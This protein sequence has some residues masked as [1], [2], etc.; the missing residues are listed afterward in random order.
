M[1]SWL[2]PTC[3]LATSL[4][5]SAI[6]DLRERPVHYV[7]GA[8]IP[9]MKTIKKT[10]D[11]GLF[12][13]DNKKPEIPIRVTEGQSVGF[14]QTDDGR[15]QAH[16]GPFKMNLPHETHDAWWRRLNDRDD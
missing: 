7:A 10:G 4:G 13:D 14:Q 5:C 11:F 16:A 2:L 8:P 3:L 15:V 1:R 6:R 9:E 12:L